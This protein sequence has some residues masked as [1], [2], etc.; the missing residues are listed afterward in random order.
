MKQIMVGVMAALAFRTPFLHAQDLKPKGRWFDHRDSA[1]FQPFH[2]TKKIKEQLP[3]NFFELGKEGDLSMFRINLHG[4]KIGDYALVNKRLCGAHNCTYVLI[5][6]RDERRFGE[7]SG[8]AIYI[9]D[10][11]INGMPIIT[12]YNQWG[13]EEG[14]YTCYVFDGKAYASVSAIKLEGASVRALFDNMAGL[15][16]IGSLSPGPK[17]QQ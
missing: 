2:P 5:D 17:T 8:S 1:I 14:I 7:V 6:G 10:Q 13:A 16:K 11:K 15:E 12:S 3:S 4:G 9:M